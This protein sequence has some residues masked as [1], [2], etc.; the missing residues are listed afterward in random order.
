MNVTG[1]PMKV[2]LPQP[3]LI[4]EEFFE[5]GQ[6]TVNA[7]EAADDNGLRYAEGYAQTPDQPGEWIA[8]A[9]CVDDDGFVIDP[10]WTDTD[11]RFV[12][13]EAHDPFCR[14]EAHP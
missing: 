2:R 12:Y 10:T 11:E 5:Q 3:R 1:S 4:G 7:A 8:H 14:E 6:C 13:I 9:W